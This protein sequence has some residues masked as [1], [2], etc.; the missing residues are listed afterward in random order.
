MGFDLAPQLVALVPGLACPQ[1]VALRLL[2]GDETI[3]Q[4]LRSGCLAK[5]VHDLSARR[6][7]RVAS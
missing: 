3:E 6:T 1:W 5:L 2:E 7:Q 4:S